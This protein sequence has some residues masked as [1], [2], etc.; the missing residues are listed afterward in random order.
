MFVTAAHFTLSFLMFRL[1]VII[2]LVVLYHVA[3]KDSHEYICQ[4]VDVSTFSEFDFV[5][6]TSGEDCFDVDAHWS[7]G[8]I[9][10]ANNGEAELPSSVKT[11]VKYCLKR[12]H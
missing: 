1:I 9:F 4:N 2:I 7:T 12:E 10:A 5:S 11:S 3:N 8:R 6:Q